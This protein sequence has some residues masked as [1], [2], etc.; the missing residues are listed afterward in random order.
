[1][2]LLSTEA[3]D[4][5]QRRRAV[6]A[7]ELSNQLLKSSS[8]LPR[9]R[10]LKGLSLEYLAAHK[11]R[12]GELEIAEKYLLEAAQVYT[13][14]IA[15]SPALKLYETQRSQVLESIADIKIKQGDP[16]A[17]ILFLDRAIS[18]KTSENRIGTAVF[19]FICPS[20]YV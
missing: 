20:L 2:T 4:F 17:A 11:S 9:Y 15:T 8:E 16:Q 18:F 1:M 19:A 12:R 3:F 6:R 14:L 13:A 10:A 7:D 5:N